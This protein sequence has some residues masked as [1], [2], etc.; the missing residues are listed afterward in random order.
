LSTFCFTGC[1]SQVKNIDSSDDSGEQEVIPV[2]EDGDGYS[3]WYLTLDS[4]TADCDDTNPNVT[5]ETELWIP[6]GPFLRGDDHTPDASPAQSVTLGEFCIQKYEVTNT[7]FLH[8]LEARMEIG[9]PNE[10][11]DGAL[12][13]DFIDGDDPYPERIIEQDQ[14][15]TIEAGYENHPV[16]EVYFTGAELYCTSI[17]LRLPTEAEWEKSARGEDGRTFPWGEGPA[18]CDRANYWPRGEDG[19][20]GEPCVND[21]SS[22]GSHPNGT[23][24]YG[25][26]DLA[27]NVS[28]WVADWYSED[29]YNDGVTLNPTGP[30]SGFT[31][32]DANPDGFVA[33]V[34]RG[35]SLGTGEGSIRTFHRTAEPEGATSN[36]MG[37]RC[38]RDLTTVTE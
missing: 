16:V 33:R 32:D 14:G 35:G 28:E 31:S 5:P 7:A 4:S 23:G 21:T 36:G 8:L 24:P 29:A 27:G 17:G 26:E 25:V 18:D 13:F 2:D 15:Y 10:N 3:P 9:T 1:I 12:L 22:V 38:V 20:P 37:F 6:G 30:D 19:L 34:A 11:D